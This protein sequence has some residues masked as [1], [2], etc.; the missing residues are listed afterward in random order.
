M[1][2]G[3]RQTRGEARDATRKDALRRRSEEERAREIVTFIVLESEEMRASRMLLGGLR[4]P[5]YRLSSPRLLSRMASS[6]STPWT[7]T[8]VREEFFNFFKSKNHPYVPSSSTIPYED[9]TL[10][11]ANAG[12]NQVRPFSAHRLKFSVSTACVV[13][14]DLPRNGR[15]S[16]RARA[17]ETRIQQSEVHS[18][19]REAQRYAILQMHGQY[20]DANAS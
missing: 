12:M 7:A 2:G 15:S 14:G 6:A 19:R 18:C 16:V 17:T 20:M 13:Q 9:P 3:R 11:F 10:L 5:L 4:H 8:R 1:C